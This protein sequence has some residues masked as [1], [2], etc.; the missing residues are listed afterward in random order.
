VGRRETDGGTSASMNSRAPALVPWRK[1][2]GHTYAC[3]DFVCKL[4]TTDVRA[5]A[6]R[7]AD[8]ETLT[9][10]TEVGGNVDCRAL[11]KVG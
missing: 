7:W 5:A 1:L 11:E 8:S 10:F 4:P 2:A 6:H 3:E 9:L